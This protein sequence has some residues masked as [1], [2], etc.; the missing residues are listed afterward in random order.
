MNGTFVYQNSEF[1]KATNM[2]EAMEVEDE[3]GISGGRLAA[4]GSAKDMKGG[5]EGRVGDFPDHWKKM[6]LDRPIIAVDLAP[7]SREYDS[8]LKHFTSSL[9]LLDVRVFRIFRIQSSF[10][11]KHYV[12]KQEE[13]RMEHDG[14]EVEEKW[15]FHGTGM[16]NVDGICRKGFDKRLCSR[17]RFGEGSYFALTSKYSHQFCPKTDGMTNYPLILHAALSPSLFAE[18]PPNS[19]SSHKQAVVS[20][21][22]AA[23][24]YRHSIDNLKVL[25]SHSHLLTAT[26]LQ[27]MMGAHQVQAEFS[28]LQNAVLP[29]GQQGCTCH[30]C[31]TASSSAPP[32][33]IGATSNLPPS[34]SSSFGGG[35]HQPSVSAAPTAPVRASPGFLGGVSPVFASAMQSLSTP[36]PIHPPHM[37]S[38][39]HQP[40]NP[41]MG[42]P[43]PFL[44]PPSSLQLSFSMGALQHHHQHFHHHQIQHLHAPPSVGFGP[45]QQQQ[46]PS[47]VSLTSS[48]SLPMPPPHGSQLQSPDPRAIA[49][50]PGLRF[51]FVSRVL[52]GQ[53]VQG[54]SSYRRPPALNPWHPTGATFD[55]CV[56]SEQNP[57]IFVVFDSNQAYPEYLVE[58]SCAL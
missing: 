51:M 50:P 31:M 56:D 24:N 29:S 37:I 26:G 43:S 32:H 54:H 58:Y 42:Q 12:L 3:E 35:A 19:T 2:M 52:V 49:A 48:V 7:N 14:R 33:S 46:Q 40:F 18:D 34:S 27:S 44:P 9:S 6:V 45:L 25:D 55:S 16:H 38:A 13:M 39:S 23:D 30:L 41:L 17:I 47:T 1:G 53:S 8:V 21:N 36:H 10:L 11:W 5:Q 28:Q 57:N 15:L 20:L 22:N 4:D